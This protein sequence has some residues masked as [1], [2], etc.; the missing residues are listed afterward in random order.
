VVSAVSLLG[1]GEPKPSV[2]GIVI[3][4]SAAE[5]MPLLAARKENLSAVTRRAALRADAAESAVCAYFSVLALLGV[6]LNTVSHISWANPVAA[7]RL[8]RPRGDAWEGVRLFER[9][10]PI[11]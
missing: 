11:G 3:L 6:G 5:V 8:G 4:L 10:T 7:H 2:P 1:Y 9:I